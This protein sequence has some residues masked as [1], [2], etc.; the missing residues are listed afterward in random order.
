VT[1]ES[2]NKKKETN[3]SNATLMLPTT[4]W[5]HNRVHM[6]RQRGIVPK[7]TQRNNPRRSFASSP[8]YG[9]LATNKSIYTCTKKKTD[10]VQQSITSPQ[11][12]GSA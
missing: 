4:Q 7:I 1:D 12:K 5:P 8:S 2:N 11:E 3:K 6:W 9:C 10:T